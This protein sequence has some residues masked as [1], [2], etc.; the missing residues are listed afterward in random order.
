M[1]RISRILIIIALMLCTAAAFCGSMQQRTLIAREGN[2]YLERVGET[3]L[4]L[5]VKGTPREMGYQH[6]VLLKDHIRQMVETLHSK[7]AE[8]SD[9]PD[10]GTANMMFDTVWRKQLPYMP[11][12]FIDEMKGLAEGCGLPFNE[13]RRANT[14]P[15]FFHCSGFAVFGGATVDG[16]LYH[17]RVLDYGVSLGYQDHAVVTIAEPD[18]YIPFVTVGYSGFIGSVTGMNLHGV[19][20]GEMGGKGQG[21]WDGAPMSFLM[22]RGMEEAETLDEAKSIFRDTKRTCEYFYVISDSKIPSAVGVSA[23][24]EKIDFVGPNESMEPLNTPIKDAV[25]LSTGDR[26]TLLTQRVKD[27]WGKL[28]PK[29]CLELMRRPVSMKDNLHCALMSPKTHELWV[30]N[31]SHTGEPASEQPFTYLDI[32]K[33]MKQMPKKS[34]K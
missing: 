16:T 12:R 20:F 11:Q 15:E 30:A 2:G 1:R 27:M 17:G 13:I 21:K 23:V 8:M 10:I 33:L 34:A 7:I 28:D 3:Q 5:H 26:Y 31:A 25:V 32:N 18:G 6:G 19:A 14:I 4:V 22:R 24:P 9:V 29:S